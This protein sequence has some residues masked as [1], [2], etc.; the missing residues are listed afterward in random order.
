MESVV[1]PRRIVALG[2]AILIT[3][4]LTSHAVG[5]GAAKWHVGDHVE[6]QDVYTSSYEKAVITEVRDYRASLGGW[7]YKAHLDHQPVDSTEVDLLLREDQIRAIKAFVPRFKRGAA[8]DVYYSKGKGRNR[9]I[10]RGVDGRGRYKIHYPGCGKEFDEAVDHSLVLAPKRLSRH[11]RTARYLIGRWVMFTPSYPTTV[12]RGGSIYRQYGPG[13]RTPPLVI[14]SNGR[15]TWYFDFGKKPVKGRWTPEA[16]V[17]GADTGT[18]S[19]DGVIIKDP[20]GKPWKVYKRTVRDHRKHITAERLCS[21]IT[22]IG[23]GV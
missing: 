9:G 16:R 14:K 12:V 17:P 13:A 22:D 3:A 2:A 19:V 10:V 11:S 5:A 18:G 1:N 21:G 4:V 7:A 8:V 6:V 15:Y 23:T 20:S